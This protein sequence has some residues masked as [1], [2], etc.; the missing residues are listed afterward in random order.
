MYNIFQTPWPLITAAVVI[1][2]ILTVFR[3]GW[4]EKKRLWQLLLPPLLALTALGLDFFV[5]TD[6]EKIEIIFQL[7]SIAVADE[8]VD[9]LANLFADNYSDP[10]HHSKQSFVHYCRALFSEPL[11]EKVKLRYNKITVA[12]P[13]ADALFEVAVHPESN[14]DLAVS[15]EIIFVKMKL[16]FTKT[17][18]KIWLIRGSQIRAINNQ[19]FNW[20]TVK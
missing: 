20:N 18:H 4:P 12:P 19:P 13:R 15:P 17:P 1:L 5:K 9:S 16:D 6:Y 3:L 14:P 10:V 8:D 7:G 11:V 2:V